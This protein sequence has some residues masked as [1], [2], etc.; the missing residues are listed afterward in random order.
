MRKFSK[1]LL[2]RLLRPRQ[3]PYLESSAVAELIMASKKKMTMG[4]I[5]GNRGFFPDHLAKTGR[6]EMFEALQKAGF[7]VVA[8]TLE[9]SKYGAVET[10]DEAKRCAELF[11]SKAGIID[12]VIVARPNFGDVRAIADTLRLA[13]LNVPV[14]IHPPPPAPR[15]PSPPK[16]LQPLP[17]KWASPIVATV[18]AAKCPPATISSSTAFLI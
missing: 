9:R 4:L 3:G 13:R 10:H 12:G 11:R 1:R 6:E 7:D 14:L 17:A 2:G 18:S 5:V 15:S 16:P 8:P